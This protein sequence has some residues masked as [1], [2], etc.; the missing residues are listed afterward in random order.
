MRGPAAV[1][2]AL[3][4]VNEHPGD[5][6]EGV[7]A[8]DTIVFWGVVHLHMVLGGMWVRDEAA[9][10]P[11][12]LTLRLVAFRKTPPQTSQVQWAS[13]QKKW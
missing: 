7:V 12:V 2:A 10:R 5:G 4:E 11:P 13:V 6:V 9:R 1:F 8:A 3:F